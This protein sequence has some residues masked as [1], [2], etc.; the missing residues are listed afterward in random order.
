MF[1]FI[2]T[3][4]SNYADKRNS[5]SN[6]QLTGKNKGKSI[7]GIAILSN[8]LF[9]VTESSHVL[10]VYYSKTFKHKRDMKVSKMGYPL[11]IA[12]SKDAK[13][14]YI[15]GR[16]SEETESQVVRIDLGGRV[17]NQWSI[18]GERGR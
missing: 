1:V 12:S 16:F 14:L 15:V 3:E 5:V 2:I 17:L 13:C 4:T 18:G 10:E 8:E 7:N 9:V 11:D 6:I